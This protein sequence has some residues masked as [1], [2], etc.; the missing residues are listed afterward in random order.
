MGSLLTNPE[1]MLQKIMHFLWGAE[2]ESGALVEVPG[3]IHIIN[4]NIRTRCGKDSR[5]LPAP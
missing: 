2:A 4:G 1:E 3:K 5:C